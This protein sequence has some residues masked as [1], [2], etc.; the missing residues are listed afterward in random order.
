MLTVEQYPSGPYMYATSTSN[1]LRSIEVNRPAFCHYRQLI[2]LTSCLLAVYG[3]ALWSAC[4]SRILSACPTHSDP[5]R[6]TLLFQGPR[7]MQGKSTLSIILRSDWMAVSYLV[8]AC[9][10]ERL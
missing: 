1:A 7:S 8:S 4:C 6:I 3:Y 5:S 10:G 9:P 2:T